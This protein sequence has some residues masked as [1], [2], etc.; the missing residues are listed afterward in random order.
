MDRVSGSA[1]SPERR[2]IP[3]Q[4]SL[5]PFVNEADRQHAEKKDH[6]PKSEGANI[7]KRHSPR[8][9]K[10]D[11]QIEDDEEQRDQIEAHVEFHTS[12]VEGIEA[13]LVSRYFFRIRVLVSHHEGRN[14][15]RQTDEASNGYKD[16]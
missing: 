4:R 6:R 3:F 2:S 9:E 16:D 8:K 1:R 7:V 15:K 13:A 10:G 14:E 11:F 5:I 12:V